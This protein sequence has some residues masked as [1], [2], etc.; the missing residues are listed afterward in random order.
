LVGN[1]GDI[2]HF[3]PKGEYTIRD[4]TTISP[5]YYWLASDW[6][7][8]YLSCTNCNQKTTFDI[9]D[10][11]NPGVIIKKTAG[12]MNQFALVDET[13]RRNHHTGNLDEEEPYRL[14]IDPCK[15]HPE[16]LLEFM[17]NGVLKP[18]AAGG[19]DREKAVYSIDVYVLQRDVLVK[20]RRE[21]YLRVMDK[22]RVVDDTFGFVKE[23]IIKGS[24]SRRHE[25][26][27]KQLE[28]EFMQLLEFL[29]VEK[30]P[31]EYIGLSRQYIHPF[32]HAYIVGIAQFLDP[33]NQHEAWYQKAVDYLEP[34]VKALNKYMEQ[35]TL[36]T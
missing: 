28:K 35:H 10:A 21:K 30:I 34:Q 36:N 8:L 1:R 14:L 26:D 17:D 2:E 31:N 23:G 12:K 29:D 15:D 27:K 24:A 4:G 13:Y 18:R 32:L 20:A 11:D 25:Y 22:I 6:A 5:G 7:N 19:I 9:L 3:R 16:P 33:V